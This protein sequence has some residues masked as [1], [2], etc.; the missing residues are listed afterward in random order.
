MILTGNEIKIQQESGG[1]YIEDFDE[2]RLNPNSYNLRLAP[3]LLVYTEAVL[4][5]KQDNRTRAITIPEGGILL[6]PGRLYLAKTMEWTETRDYVPKLE[7]RSSIGRLGLAIHVTAGFGDVGFKGR[8]TLELECVQPVIVYPGMEIC[9]ISYHTV[10]GEVM[11]RYDGK[12]QNSKDV[13][14]SR[15]WREMNGAE[16]MT[17]KEA[18]KPRSTPT[19]KSILEEA[20]RC[21]C[22]QREQD[23]G[24]PE[25]SFQRI[26]D[27]WNAYCG[28]DDGLG[29]FSV[30]D[31]AVMMGLLKVARIASNPQHMDSWVDLAGYAACGGEI[32]GKEE[33]K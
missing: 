31:V 25:D 8:W 23:Y 30:V 33:T 24:G 4:D 17:P 10:C 15:I 16:S 29:K 32:A 22:G 7:G 21:V 1:L 2:S 6:K 26:A 11:D 19:R 14:S 27:L 13:V 20:E 9:Q 12:Y 5:P 3:E 18:H 28:F